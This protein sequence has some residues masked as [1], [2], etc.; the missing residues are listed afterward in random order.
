MLLTLM[1]TLIILGAQALLV[2]GETSLILIRYGRVN[3]STLDDLRGNQLIALIMKDGERS[4]EVLRF[5]KVLCLLGLGSQIPYYAGELLPK[6]GFVGWI[7]FLLVVALILVLFYCVGEFIPRALATRYPNVAL[8]LCAPILVFLK[9]ATVPLRKLS[10]KQL[11]YN[12][13][14]IEDAAPNPL[15]VAVQLR[16]LGLDNNSFTPVVRSIVNRSVQMQ[17][18]VVHDV[19][20]PRNEVVFYDLNQDVAT[21]LKRMKRAG[22][23]R[24]PL[25]RGDLDDCLGIIHIK[26]IFRSESGELSLNPDVVMRPTGSF[27]LETPLEEALQRMLR[28]KF[29]MGLVYDNFGGALGV[30]TLERILEELVGDIQDEFDS[31]EDP[32]E[33]LQ[34]LGYYQISGQAPIHEVEARLGIEIENDAVSTFGGLVAGELGRIPTAGE[35]LHAHGLRIEIMRVDERRILTPRVRLIEVTDD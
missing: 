30:V 33:E 7:A 24:Y 29:H 5:G 31:E 13:L 10:S 17:D 22:H 14:G 35:E 34:E 1:F 19:L 21:N 16:A 9:F 2:L 26:D 15:D 12:W 6:F 4:G 28:T 18:L 3:R 27:L 25:C 20:L 23:T 8:R 32:I 11:I